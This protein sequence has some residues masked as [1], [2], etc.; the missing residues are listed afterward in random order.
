MLRK[1]NFVLPG[2]WKLF[3]VFCFAFICI[4]NTE[5]SAQAVKRISGKITD[6]ETGEP[7]PYV[8]VFVKLPNHTTKGITSDFSGLYHLVAPLASSDTI[9]ATYVGYLQAKKPLPKEHTAT[10]DFQLKADN[11]L[12]KTVTI[13]PKSYVNPAWA[14]LENVVKHKNENNLEKLNSYEYESYTRLELSVTNISDKMKQRKVMKQILPIMDSLKKMAGDDGKPILPVFMSE[15]VADYYYQKNPQQ[16]TENIKRTKT[17]GVG[18]EDETLISQI[19]GSSFQQYNFYK[20]YVRLANKDFISP[21]TDSWKTF[22]NY[23]LTDEHDKINGREYYK[24]EFKPKRSH[25]LSFVGVMW[26]T[27][28]DYALYRIDMSVTP[29]ANLDFLNK[30]RIQQEMVQPQGTTAWIPEKTRITVHVSNIAKNWSGFL[31]KFY[32][33]NKNFAVNKTYPPAVFKEPLTMSDDIT[34]QDESYWTR[35][36]PEPLT[37]DDK[38]VYHIIDTVK[39]LPMVRTYADIAG[40]LINGYYRI[41]KFSYGPYLYTYSYN[42]VQGSVLRLGGTTNKYFSDQLILGGYVSYGFRDKRWNFNGSVDYIFSRKPWLQAGVSFTRDLGQT[43]YQFEN[44]SKNNNV[45]R[46]SIRNGR[47]TRRGP[48]QQNDLRAYVQTDIARE[49]NAKLTVDRRTFDPLYN[50]VYFSPAN[51]QLYTNYQVAEAIGEL[52]WQPGRRLLQSSK[53][54]KRIMLGEGTDNPVVT[55]RYTHGFKAFGGD[56][57]YN[58]FAA[59]ITEKVHMGIF[60]K[61]EYAVTGG[62][63]PSSLPLP[64]LEN[65]RY[66]FNTMRFLEFTSNRYVSLTYTQHMEGLITNSIPLLKE[67]NVRTVADFNVLDGAL[68]DANGGRP[69]T[70]RRPTRNLEGI[71]YV[72]A[73]YGLENIFNFIRVDFLHRLTH[74]DHVDE[75][76]ALPS[77]FAVRVSVQFRL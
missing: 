74:R 3:P 41:G 42:D 49:W 71:P 66:N 46:A 60:G 2:L 47:I 48:F 43:G 11:Q 69:S 21:I 77:N 9:Y 62:Y 10:V 32:L 50:F 31:G 36:R 27:H 24:I 34:K 72:E 51:S 25:D 44:F 7:L 65:H 39:N 68:N 73:G 14:I 37:E 23:E 12:L 16:K 45:F 57:S 8:T 75:T 35:N 56:F 29:D 61:G 19:I 33:S 18:I 17:S 20:N 38:K 59:N 22:Y 40:M 30:I 13:T 54:N 6:A 1:A 52:Q 70:P 15:S 5:A 55:F 76:G 4:F 28:D 26:I 58:K 67:L 64:L 53:I 63:I